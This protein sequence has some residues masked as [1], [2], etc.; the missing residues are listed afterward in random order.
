MINNDNDNNT[1]NYMICIMLVIHYVL[2]NLQVPAF[3]WTIMNNR[4]KEEK[5]K[6]GGDGRGE[7]TDG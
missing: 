1:F 3:V 2:T 4:Y 5:G 7:D 6:Q